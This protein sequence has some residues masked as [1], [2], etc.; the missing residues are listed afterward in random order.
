MKKIPTLYE[1]VF[2]GHKVVDIIEK[3]PNEDV[4]RRVLYGDNVKATIKVDGSCCAYIDGVFY[5]RYDAKKGKKPPVGAI[6]CEA[7]PDPVTGHW[8]HWLAVSA[9]EKGDRWLIEA[10][11]NSMLDELYPDEGAFTF[12]AIGPHFNANP[13]GLKRDILVPHGESVIQN[14]SFGIPLIRKFLEETPVEGVVFWDE[15]GPF[16][17]IKRKDFGL[18]WPCEGAIYELMF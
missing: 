2:D 11:S 16:A 1:R 3:F 7:A 10:A 6:P 5:K 9:D 4:A 13:Y 18:P 17:K 14:F 8:P 15:D 12:E